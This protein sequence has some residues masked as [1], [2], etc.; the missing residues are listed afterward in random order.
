MLHVKVKMKGTQLCPTLCDP[1]DYT[2]HGILQARIL[3]WVALPFSRGSPNP[4]VEPRSPTLQGDSL[5][6]ELSGKPCICFILANKILKT[7]I[8]IG[9]L[10]DYKGW[11]QFCIFLAVKTKGQ[12]YKEQTKTTE[13]C[14]DLTVCSFLEPLTKVRGNNLKF[15][16]WLKISAWMKNTECLSICFLLCIFPTTFKQHI[17]EK[18]SNKFIIIWYEQYFLGEKEIRP[19]ISLNHM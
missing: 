1:K 3:E 14:Q 12:H 17:Y 16:L 2:V 15:F 8:G 6:T 5:P 19:F 4:G 7:K 13:H 11:I 9:S 18:S 10:V